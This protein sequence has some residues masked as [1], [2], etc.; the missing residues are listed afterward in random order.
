[1]SQLVA[2][3]TLA[4]RFGVKSLAYGPPGTGKTPIVKTAPRPVMCV[5][6]PGMLSMRDATNIPAWEAYTTARV[7]EFFEWLFKSPEARNFD[8]VCVDSV[9]QLAEMKLAEELPKQKDP[10]RAYGLMSTWVMDIA[11]GL[12]YLPNKHVYLIA[13][14]G[15][16]DEAGT[17]SKRPYFPGQDL[18][19][20]VPHLYDEILYIAEAAVMGLPMPTIA[21]R[22][23]STFGIL[24][25]DR[26]GKL[27]EL[28]PPNL[29]TLFQ[30][31]M[32]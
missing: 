14:Q 19:V 5:V 16:F 28:E 15:T 4:Q 29:T 25:R 3:S 22:T 24:A 27:A 31:C 11:S 18:N 17:N 26:S 10:R 32:T 9:S 7:T 2:A 21:I 23:K 13:K 8:T 6:E 12:Y 30:K 1:M 20:R